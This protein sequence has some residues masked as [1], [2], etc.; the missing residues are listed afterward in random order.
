MPV[1]SEKLEACH[2]EEFFSYADLINKYC[3]RIK[4]DIMDS[5]EGC[6]HDIDPDSAPDRETPGRRVKSEAPRVNSDDKNAQEVDP[7][8]QLLKPLHNLPRGKNTWD[9]QFIK[10]WWFWPLSAVVIIVLFYVY[11]HIWDYFVE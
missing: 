2:V 10:K 9:P 11:P 5:K 8:Y 1:R 4:V 7:M 6:K 3:D